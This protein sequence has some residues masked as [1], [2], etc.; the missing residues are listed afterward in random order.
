MIICA[1]YAVLGK[2][3]SSYMIKCR[4]IELLLFIDRHIA[5]HI[6]KKVPEH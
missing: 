5:D 4:I 1:L 3:N 6:N 2:K